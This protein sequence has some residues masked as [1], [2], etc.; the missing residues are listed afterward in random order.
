MSCERHTKLADCGGNYGRTD[1][2]VDTQGRLCASVA[3]YRGMQSPQ[4][5]EE[6]RKGSWTQLC[7]PFQLRPC[8]YQYM[9]KINN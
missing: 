2:P 4:S 8:C 3:D 6:V 5:S 7:L 9:A 1:L